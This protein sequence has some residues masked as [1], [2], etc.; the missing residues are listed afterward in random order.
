MKYEVRTYVGTT[1]LK[2][3]DTNQQIVL[4]NKLIQHPG[5]GI[6]TVVTFATTVFFFRERSRCG[7]SFMVEALDMGSQPDQQIDN[8]YKFFIALKTKRL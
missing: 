2:S 4:E 6:R 1:A 7:M 8:H 3:V 5:I